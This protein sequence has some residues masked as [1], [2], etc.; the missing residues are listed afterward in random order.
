MIGPKALRRRRLLKLLI[1]LMGV[2]DTSDILLE[3][4][5]QFQEQGLPRREAPQGIPGC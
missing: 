2:R 4:V 5:P 1:I 3:R